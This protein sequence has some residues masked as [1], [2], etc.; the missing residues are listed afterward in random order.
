MIDIVELRK[1]DIGRWVL[2]EGP[3]G[4]KEKGRIKSWNNKYIFVVYKCDHRWDRFQDFT[5]AATN[6]EDLRYTTISEVI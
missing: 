2:Y 6:P 4:E 3:A 5:A 1:E